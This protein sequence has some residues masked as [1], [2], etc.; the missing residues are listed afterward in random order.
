MEELPPIQPPEP[1]VP[2]AL[3]VELDADENTVV[4]RAEAHT[5]MA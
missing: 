3:P 4:A 2:A 1:T 5:W